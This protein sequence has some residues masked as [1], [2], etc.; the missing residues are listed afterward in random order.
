MV[1]SD[2]VRERS[3][4]TVSL[5]IQLANAVTPFAGAIAALRR[6]LPAFFGFGER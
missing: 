2:R 1:R 6:F 4:S 5:V 3:D